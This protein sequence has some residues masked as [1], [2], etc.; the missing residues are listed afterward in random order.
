MGWGG[1]DSVEVRSGGLLVGKD[2]RSDAPFARSA[3][4]GQMRDRHMKV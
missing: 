4:D 1:E 3:K 2:L